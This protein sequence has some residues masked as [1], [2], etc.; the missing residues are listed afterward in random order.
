MPLDERDRALI[1][2]VLDAARHLREMW[3]GRSLDELLNNRTLQW[4]TDRGFNV[5]GKAA[6]RQL[7]A[8]LEKIVI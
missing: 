1:H 4:V 5:I 7:I 2:D 3:R 6:R 8:E